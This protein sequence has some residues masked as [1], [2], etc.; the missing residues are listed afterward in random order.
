MVKGVCMGCSNGRKCEG[1]T[2]VKKVFG[3]AGGAVVKIGCR[4]EQWYKRGAG[5]A[6]CNIL[7]K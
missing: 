2:V 6:V 4:G 7:C 5:S 3:D 1:E